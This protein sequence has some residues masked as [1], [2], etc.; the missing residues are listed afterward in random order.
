MAM[1]GTLPD[2]MGCAPVL[3]KISVRK[4]AALLEAFS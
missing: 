4:K 1:V 2:C 3:F